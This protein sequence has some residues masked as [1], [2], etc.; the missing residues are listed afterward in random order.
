MRLVF[1]ERADG[2]PNHRT[3]SCIL[4]FIVLLALAGPF[5]NVLLDKLFDLAPWWLLLLLGIMLVFSLLGALSRLAFHQR[6]LRKRRRARSHPCT[7]TDH[8]IRVY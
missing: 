6:K 3:A 7:F 1:L 8:R 5:I 4:G 2:W